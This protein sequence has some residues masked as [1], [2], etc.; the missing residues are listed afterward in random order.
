[1]ESAQCVLIRWNERPT[2]ISRSVIAGE[3]GVLVNVSATPDGDTCLRK[4]PYAVSAVASLRRAGFAIIVLAHGG[5]GSEGVPR[6]Q[7]LN[8]T[9]AALELLDPGRRLID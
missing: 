5:D 3:N 1:M 2:E 7:L 6:D 8:T 4:L 9:T